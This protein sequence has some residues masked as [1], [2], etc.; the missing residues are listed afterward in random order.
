MAV[1]NHELSSMPTMARSMHP[2]SGRASVSAA[3][4]TAQDDKVLPAGTTT[5]TSTGT[6]GVLDVIASAG[7]TTSTATTSTTE[8]TSES[9]TYNDDTPQGEPATATAAAEAKQ[10]HYFAFLK[11]RNFYL[12]LLSG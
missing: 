12:I 11:T 1:V 10:E 5:T 6:T 2:P 3:A 7:P 9:R 4:T 8:T